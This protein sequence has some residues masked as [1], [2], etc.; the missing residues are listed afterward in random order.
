[1][2]ILSHYIEYIKTNILPLVYTL[3]KLDDDGIKK[4]EIIKT[5]TID[6]LEKLETNIR[7]DNMYTPDI[8]IYHYD[9]LISVF[10]LHIKKMIYT[11]CVI[12]NRIFVNKEADV[13]FVLLFCQG[14]YTTLLY[15]QGTAKDHGYLKM[16]I[17]GIHMNKL[18][19]SCD[20]YKHLSNPVIETPNAI[21]LSYDIANTALPMFTSLE[22]LSIFMDSISHK[23]QRICILSCLNYN[24]YN[25]TYK[26]NNKPQL[27]VDS[28]NFIEYVDNIYITPIIPLLTDNGELFIYGGDAHDILKDRFSSVFEHVCDINT[29]GGQLAIYKRNNKSASLN[30]GSRKYKTKRHIKCNS[31]KTKK[32]RTRKH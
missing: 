31:H 27:K 5:L 32:C 15:K 4:F 11:M 16:F 24:T 13:Y 17:T 28:K 22:E 21:E 10:I 12:Y 6:Q 3:L 20:K 19:L 9:E 30:G 2:N 8:I 23:I 18:I 1:M 25:Y 26:K 14:D 7:S 29:H